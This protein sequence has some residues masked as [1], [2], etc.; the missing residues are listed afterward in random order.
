MRTDD[1][2]VV[3]RI[4]RAREHSAERALVQ[5][6]QAVSRA[7]VQRGKTEDAVAAFAIQRRAQEET[8]LRTL[9]AGLVTSQQMRVAAAHLAGIVAHAES[10]RQSA[11]RAA[12]QEA[13]C[14]DIARGAQQA[15]AA[16]TRD[17]L[18]VSTLH[19]QVDAAERIATGR[20]ADRNMQEVA[21]VCSASR[22]VGPSP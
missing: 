1:V 6:Q 20:E 13:A 16:A 15:F 9:S 4:R 11:V 12:Q 19:R 3:L 22:S 21:G 5:A 18:G 14:T 17:C 2:A 8:V 7:S 10:L